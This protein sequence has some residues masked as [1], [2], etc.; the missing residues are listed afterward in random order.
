VKKL[1]GSG[2]LDPVRELSISSPRKIAVGTPS[3]KK[4]TKLMK[5]GAV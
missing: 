4:D 3:G 1:V 5:G 2:I